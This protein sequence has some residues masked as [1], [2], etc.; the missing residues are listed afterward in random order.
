MGYKVPNEI[1]EDVLERAQTLTSVVQVS[2]LE[3]EIVTHGNQCN[4][5]V[6]NSLVTGHLGKMIIPI[7]ETNS[8][9]TYGVGIGTCKDTSVKIFIHRGVVM[10]KISQKQ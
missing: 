6:L 4:C 2:D 7:G 10:L 3:D 8:N 5:A 9:E 1:Y